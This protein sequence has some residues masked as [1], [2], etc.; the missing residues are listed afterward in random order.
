MRSAEA[1]AACITLNFSDR[2]E[3]GC[4]KRS[5]YWMKATSA[6]SDRAPS[7]TRPPP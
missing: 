3:I 6:P 7:R 4:Q 2:S 1:I 5:E